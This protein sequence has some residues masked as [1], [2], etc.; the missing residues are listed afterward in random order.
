MDSL[1]DKDNELRTLLLDF[2]AVMVQLRSLGLVATQSKLG[3]RE[4]CVS[5]RPVPLA[6]LARL[7]CGTSSVGQTGCSVRCWPL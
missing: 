5:I 6:G 2:D 3:I 4:Q 7:W 1:E